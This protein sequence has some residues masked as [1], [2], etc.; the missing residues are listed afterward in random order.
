MRSKPVQR[1]RSIPQGDPEAPNIFLQAIDVPASHLLEICEFDS[2]GY[3]MF[4]VGSLPLLLFADNFWLLGRNSQELNLMLAA[5]MQC[6]RDVD[7]DV[8]ISECVW[9]TTESDDFKAHEVARNGEVVVRAPRAKGFKALGVQIQMDGGFKL[10][11]EAREQAFWRMFWN[12]SEVLCAQSTPLEPRLRLV[13]QIFQSSLWC[14]GSWNLSKKQCTHLRGLQQRAYDKVVGMK[15]RHLEPQNFFF[16]R[17]S[18]RFR[19]LR[20][21]FHLDSFDAIYHRMVFIWGGYLARFLRFDPMR[22]TFRVFQWQNY[23]SI[24]SFSTDDGR[25]HHGR[26][27]K[28]WRWERPFYKYFPHEDWVSVAQNQRE[29]HRILETMV[30]WRLHFR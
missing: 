30:E 13:G 8:P 25:Q 26:Y 5:W 28:M 23:K 3:F 21:R 7:L 4:A 12:H 19:D 22:W 11:L 14:A 18:A 10:E 9:T 1:Q 15:P 17:A 16:A 29:W 20:L 27:L 2:W 6:L 24:K